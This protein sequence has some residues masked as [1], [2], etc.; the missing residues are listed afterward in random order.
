VKAAVFEAAGR[1]LAV[2]DVPDP[3]PGPADLV[4][5]V[6]ACGICGSDLHLADVRG[7]DGMP[8]LPRGAVMG[9]EFAGEVVA[10]GSDVRDAWRIGARVTALPY[11]GCGTCAACVSGAGRCARAVELGLGRLP[12]AYAEYVRVGARETLALPDAIG[13]AAGALVEPLAVGLHAVHV[14]RLERA[15]SVLIVGAGPI[16]LAVAA[17]CRFFGARAVVVSDL[18]PARL[19]RAANLGATACIDAR[20]GDVID[21][22]KRSAG[23][24]PPVVF[25]CV[26]VP[27]SQQLAMD[28]APTDG[29]IVV[30]G[31][32]MQPD[33]ILPV[34]AVTKELQVNYVFGYRRADFA[35]TIDM[36]AAGRLDPLPMISR[37]V[38]FAAF[39]AAFE[40]LKTSKH[41]CKVMLEPGAA[42]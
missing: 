2:Q 36:L 37:T 29:R 33:T 10:A 27:G 22:V 3:T 18:A 25:D 9:H 6:T 35:F 38:G 20:G 21:E 41:D 5:R 17:W 31:V 8:G 26:G 28:Y 30:V 42:R 16:G 1:P 24:R 7:G 13:D 32:C 23:A 39:P 12:G 40:A 34:K 19:E 15:E 11:V 14:A 4:L